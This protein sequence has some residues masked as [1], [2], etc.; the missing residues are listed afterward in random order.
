MIFISFLLFT[1][2][3]CTFR[4]HFYFGGAKLAFIDRLLVT[5]PIILYILFIFTSLI[6]IF[7]I[8]PICGLDA[9]LG[10]DFSGGFAGGGT[11]SSNASSEQGGVLS[12]VIV[13]FH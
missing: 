13:V 7:I 3:A 9:I 8:S 1:F 10:L 12:I 6:F 5:N 11:P 2:I 4:L